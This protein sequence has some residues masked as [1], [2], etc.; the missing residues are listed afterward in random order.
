M[1]KNKEES[2][3]TKVENEVVLDSD[4]EL[5][6]ILEQNGTGDDNGECEACQ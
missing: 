3:I 2:T 4:A 1:D 5:L 6:A